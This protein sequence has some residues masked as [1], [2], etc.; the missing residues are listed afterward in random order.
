[1]NTK[2]VFASQVIKKRADEI[3]FNGFRTILDR[4]EAVLADAKKVP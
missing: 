1:M 3:N 2:A 4:I